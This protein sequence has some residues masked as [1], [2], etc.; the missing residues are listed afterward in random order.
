MNNTKVLIVTPVYEDV[1]SA[2]LLFQHLKEQ[3]P[4]LRIVAVDDG[5]IYHPMQGE[6]LETLGIKGA[7]ITL[8]RNLGHQGAIAVG[9][10]YVHTFMQDYDCVVVMD[11]DGEDTPESIQELLRGFLESNVDVRVAERKRRN[12]SFK[13]IQFYRIYKFLFRM[14]TGKVINFGNFMALKP[15]A[16]SRLSAMNEI[17][18]H[19]AAS[20]IASRLRVEGCKIDRGIR[21]VGASKMNFVGL[22]LHGFKGVMVFSEQVLIRMGGA[23][24]VVAI[25]SVVVI[26]LAIILKLIDAASPGWFTTVIGS[27]IAIFLQTGVLTLITLMITG[28]VRVSTLNQVDFNSFIDHVKEIR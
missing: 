12:E 15:R 17:W 8:R 9:L 25:S 2:R 27:T 4:E 6:V 10:C 18:I 11:S 16:V 3:V 14:L 24:L 23:S 20:V 19:L 22:V 21:Y 28:L 5:S 7:V 13:F 26:F 1:E